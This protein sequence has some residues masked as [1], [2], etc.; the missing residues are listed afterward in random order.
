MNNK[1]RDIALALQL[2][3]LSVLLAAPAT[4]TAAAPWEYG[5]II[6][7]GGIYTDN[8]FLDPD[9]LE[10]SDKIL[11]I[12]PEFYLT[13]D[14]DRTRADL[15]YRPE[16]YYYS[17]NSDADTVY[18]VVDANLTQALVRDKLFVYLS[19]TNSQSIVVPEGRLPTSNVPI[20]GNRIDSTVLEARPYLEQRI[21]AADLLLEASYIDTSYDDPL[22]QDNE[23]KSARFS[24]TNVDRQEGIAWGLSYSYLELEY[25]L[26]PGWE[27]QRASLDLGYWVNGTTRLFAVGGAETPIEDIRESNLDDEFW[28]A[29]LQYR[30]NER[31]DLELAAGERSYGRSFRLDLN[32]QLRRGFT[33]LTYA[34]TPMSRGALPLGYRPI[35]DTDDLDTIFDRPGRSDRFLRRRAEWSTSLE[36]PKSQFSLR[37]FAERR[38]ERTTFDGLPLEDEEYTGGAIRWNWDVGA[39]TSIGLGGDY[40]TRESA[41][42]DNELTRLLVDLSY[43]FS[44]RT[45]LRASYMR[46]EQDGSQPSGFDYTEQQYRLYFRIEL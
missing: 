12:A 2:G 3:A 45:S 5:A 23:S 14:G 41:S 33:A 25:E 26:S 38:E 13:T 7:I 21:G 39:R 31:L 44:Q 1:N 27:F 8:V 4:R 11:T 34:E 46:S 36:L 22:I 29:G 16:A 30:P 37:I 20:S 40:S 10:E 17:E 15:R 19:A 43:R 42:L 28:E 32:Y 35:N 18:H 24:L 6:D 9:G